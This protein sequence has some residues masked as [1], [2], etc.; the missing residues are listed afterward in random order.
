MV[1]GGRIG[2]GRHLKSPHLA[3]CR[4]RCGALAKGGWRPPTSRL[5]SS[6]GIALASNDG[7]RTRTTTLDRFTF[8]KSAAYS[9]DLLREKSGFKSRKE[10]S[11]AHVRRLHDDENFLVIALHDLSLVPTIPG[12][13]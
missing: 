13:H 6:A 12:L 5:L 2:E 9:V 11:S 4:E 10:S 8:D 3:S 7:N 1:S